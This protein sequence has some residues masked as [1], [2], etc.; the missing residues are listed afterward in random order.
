MEELKINFSYVQTR[1]KFNKYKKLIDA[2][3]APKKKLPDQVF[4]KTFSDYFF[5]EFDW[6]LTDEFWD[7]I[8]KLTEVSNDSYVLLAVLDPD[9]EKYYFK[10]FHYY[11]W[12]VIPVESSS[13]DYFSLLLREPSENPN[14]AVHLDSN[15]VVWLPSS[16]TW[17]IWGDRS[18]GMTILG[19]DIPVLSSSAWNRLSPDYLETISLNFTKKEYFSNFIRRLSLNYVKR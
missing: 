19:T 16:M 3:V 5:D 9:P 17:V 7:E 1:S 6:S 10:N 13:D 12:A 11:N 2:I 8:K 18:L 4:K 15:T 14:D